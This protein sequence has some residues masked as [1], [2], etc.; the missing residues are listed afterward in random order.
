[1]EPVNPSE[2]RSGC[3]CCCGCFTQRVRVVSAG[4]NCSVPTREMLLLTWMSQDP[5]RRW[6]GKQESY[7]QKGQMLRDPSV[8]TPIQVRYWVWCAYTHLAAAAF[9]FSGCSNTHK[10]EGVTVR[11][12]KLLLGNNTAVFPC[13]KLSVNAAVQQ[14]HDLFLQ[15]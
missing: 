14:G 15:Q 4:E 11:W 8:L 6:R 3:C 9:C 5:E 13:V 1:M 2:L 7:F 10:Q 12:G